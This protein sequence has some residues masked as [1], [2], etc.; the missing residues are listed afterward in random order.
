[1]TEHSRNISRQDTKSLIYQ[2]MQT[3]GHTFN[4][5]NPTIHYSHIHILH[6][7]LILESINKLDRYVPDYKGDPNINAIL[8]ELE[9]IDDEMEE[10][11]VKFVKLGN[12]GASHGIE[13]LPAVAFFKKGTPTV[14]EGDLME[15]EDLLDWFITQLEPNRIEEVTANALDRLVRQNEHVAVLFSHAQSCPVTGMCPDQ[16]QSEECATALRRLEQIDDET[17]EEHIVFVKTEDPKA[18]SKHRVQS[19]PQLVFFEH[20]I[21]YPYTGDL[22]QEG[23]VLDWILQQKSNEEIEEVT[24]SMLGEL[25][26]TYNNLVVLFCK[27]SWTIL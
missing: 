11:E 1:M 23:Q 24:S 17:D 22:T 26:D 14:Y 2:H 13:H 6:Q 12:G 15:E 5:N 3:T 9:N 19:L 4:I 25:L 16:R 8:T 7:R 18:A 10:M 27:S 21:P 20:S